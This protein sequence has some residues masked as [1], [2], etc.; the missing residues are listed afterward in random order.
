MAEKHKEGV[1]GRVRSRGM[2]DF[3]EDFRGASAFGTCEDRKIT[4][5]ADL[6]QR[7]APKVFPHF[8]DGAIRED[9]SAI[10]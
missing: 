10:R 6:G 3:S 1:V 4:G 7:I 5:R 9:Q 2:P 8:S